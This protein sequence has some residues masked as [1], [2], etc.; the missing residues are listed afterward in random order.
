M[1]SFRLQVPLSTME[2][3]WFLGKYN[4]FSENVVKLD[5]HVLTWATVSLPTSILCLLSQHCL[6]HSTD[7]SLSLSPSDSCKHE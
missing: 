7:P 5:S 2:Y 6:P 1:P 3:F 4:D